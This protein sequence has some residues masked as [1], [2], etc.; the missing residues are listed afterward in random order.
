MSFQIRRVFKAHGTLGAFEGPVFGMNSDVVPQSGV[1][2]E[3]GPTLRALIGPVAGVGSQVDL[4]VVE[5]HVRPIAMMANEGSLGRVN[6]LV[7]PQTL[8][9]LEKFFADVARKGIR[10]AVDPVMSLQSRATGEG[11]GAD[12]AAMSVF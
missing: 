1:G 10:D 12:G 7:F 11:V 5:S 8:R 3:P 6:L 2:L 4:E 9:G